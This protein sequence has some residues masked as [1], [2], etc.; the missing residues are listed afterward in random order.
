[1]IAFS[2]S[3]SVVL[4]LVLLLFVGM[5]FMTQTAASN[6]LL[7]TLVRPDMRGRVMAFFT[8]AVMGTTPFGA[9]L[10]GSL[11]ERIGAPRTIRLGGALCMLGAFAFLRALPRL[12]REIRP[13]YRELGI[14]PIVAVNDASEVEDAVK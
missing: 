12:R 1:L 13:I 7:Q 14:L 6:T 5:G 10:A 9:L 8:M 11:A 4:S 3:R 2:F